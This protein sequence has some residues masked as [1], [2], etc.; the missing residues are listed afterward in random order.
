MEKIK[1]ICNYYYEFEKFIELVPVVEQALE[2]P[3]WIKGKEKLEKFMHYDLDDV[4]TNVG[5]LKEAIHEIEVQKKFRKYEYID[6]I[7]CFIYSSITEFSKTDKVKGTP[8][9]EK[10]IENIKGI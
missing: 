3:Q 6:K 2:C 9:P 1:D 8:I 10:F 5:E 4:Y 7:I